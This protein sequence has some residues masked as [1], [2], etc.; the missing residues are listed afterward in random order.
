MR[1]L[2]DLGYRHALMESPWI[3]DP[4]GLRRGAPPRRVDRHVR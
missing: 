3:T 4:P 2:Y 1:E